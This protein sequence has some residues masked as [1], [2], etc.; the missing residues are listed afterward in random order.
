V[1]A[2]PLAAIQPQLQQ[3][4]LVCLH[5]QGWPLHRNLVVVQHADKYVFR[6]LTA[7]LDVLAAEMKVR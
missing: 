7:F 4:S 1:S 3:Q 2:L 5:V 6:A